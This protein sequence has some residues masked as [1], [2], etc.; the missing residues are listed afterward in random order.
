MIHRHKPGTKFYLK[1]HDW[2]LHVGRVLGVPIVI[3][4]SFLFMLAARGIWPLLTGKGLNGALS[5]IVIIITA[6]ALVFMHE[7]GHALEGKKH[8]IRTRDIVFFPIGCA[9]EMHI[10]ENPRDELHIA[11]AGPRVNIVLA[12]VLFPLV[13]LLG[14]DGF[15]S[16]AIF[17]LFLLNVLIAAFNLLPAFPMDGGRILRAFLAMR[18]DRVEATWIAARIAQGFAVLMFVSGFWLGFSMWLVAAFVAVM[19]QMEARMTEDIADG[20]GPDIKGAS[21]SDHDLPASI[22]IG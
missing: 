7:F 12:L 6:F 10:P 14:V 8:G 16:K 1:Y 18:M 22:P 11:F 17:M 3:H 21:F 13:L 19:A 20:C 2:H 9:A 4:L 15:V 5:N